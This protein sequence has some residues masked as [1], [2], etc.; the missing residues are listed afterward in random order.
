MSGYVDAEVLYSYL[1]A[2][3]SIAAGEFAPNASDVVYTNS[4]SADGCKLAAE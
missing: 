4:L 3:T 2:K 1:K